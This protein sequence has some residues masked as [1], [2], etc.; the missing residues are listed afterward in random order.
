VKHLPFQSDYRQAFEVVEQRQGNVRL[1]PHTEQLPLLLRALNFEFYRALP[2]RLARVDHRGDAFHKIA[3]KTAGLMFC[4]HINASRLDLLRL[5]SL[6]DPDLVVRVSIVQQITEDTPRGACH[7][8][9]FYAGDDFFPEIYLSGKRLVFAGHVLQ[10]FTQRVPN[11][12]GEDLSN[13]LLTFFG[14]PMISLAVGSGR[15]FIVPYLGSLLAFTYNESDTEF[16]ITT[17]LTIN[18]INSLGPEYPPLTF[19]LHYGSAFTKPK[20]RHWLPT[21]WML[22]LC[23]SW[24]QKVPLPPPYVSRHK[25]TWGNI[26]YWVRDDARNNG[27]GPGSRFCFLD[28]IPGPCLMAIRPGHA[29]PQFNELEIYKKA[30]PNSDWDAIFAKRDATAPEP[31]KKSR[32]NPET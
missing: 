17:C 8:F 3:L 5:L 2:P 21:K 9:R 10:R 32:L 23:K 25:D 26:A 31:R 6:P 1:Y 12:V 18:E 16:F 27:H 30:H 29:E 4:A 28:Q 19:N 24:E 7:R 11:K 13:L 20:L 22:D 14:S 15:A